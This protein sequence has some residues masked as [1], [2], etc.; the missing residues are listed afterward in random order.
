MGTLEPAGPPEAPA[1]GPA[2]DIQRSPTR[3]GFVIAGIQKAGTTSLYWTICTHPQISPAT[4]R[5]EL[6]FF[7]DEKID[8]SNPP[9]QRYHRHIRKRKPALLAGEASPRYVFWPGALERM[10]AYNP[11][12]RIILSFRDPIE[13]A[14]SHWT[15]A[16]GKRGWKW[17]F[18]E[19]LRQGRDSS[20]PRPWQEYRS[21]TARTIVARGYYGAQ[22]AHALEVYPEDQFLLLDFHH[23]FANMETSLDQVTQF[24][25]VQ[26]FAKPPDVPPANTAVQNLVARPP[27]ADDISAL[28]ELYVDDLARF[29]DLSG[30]D[31][32]TWTTMRLRAGT[33]SSADVAAQMHDRASLV[34]PVTG[35]RRRVKKSDVANSS[36]SSSDTPGEPVTRAASG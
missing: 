8:W 33:L 12:M 26:P 28:A 13:R 16:A 29:A 11:E 31:V 5:K 21:S 27:T 36:D 34:Q 17:N 7:D 24:L 25:G 35:I 32:S 4:K 2:S 22:I 30:I 23:V 1:E 19:T 20:W 15:M 9:Y 10:W 14:F 3:F 18:S 6:H